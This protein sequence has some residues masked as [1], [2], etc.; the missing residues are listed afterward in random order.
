MPFDPKGLFMA[1]TTKDFCSV[2][3]DKP[4][5]LMHWKLECVYDRFFLNGNCNCDKSHNSSTVESVC[6]K[7][8]SVYGGQSLEMELFAVK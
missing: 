7:R 3:F 5:S 8:T 4:L 1:S 2:F 6:I